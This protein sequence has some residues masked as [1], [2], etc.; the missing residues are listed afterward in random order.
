[1]QFPCHWTIAGVQGSIHVAR[2]PGFYLTIHS[3]V[4]TV[5][6]CPS[7]A[8]LVSRI[9]ICYTQGN[10]HFQNPHN[11]AQIPQ[12]VHTR[13]HLAMQSCT[14]AGVSEEIMGSMKDLPVQL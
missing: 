9:P 3:A 8:E 4:A 1:M 6:T 2:M 13:L 14:N 7:F 12:E 10:R 5:R 11:N